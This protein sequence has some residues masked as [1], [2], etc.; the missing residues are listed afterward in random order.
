M[1]QGGICHPEEDRLFT[2]NELS[3][4]M[5]IPDDYSLSGNWNQ[6]AKTIGNMVPPAMIASLA[7]SLYEKVLL[8]S[9]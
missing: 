5:G 4:L 1:G 6:K 7:G 3:R 2:I 9:Y 8:P